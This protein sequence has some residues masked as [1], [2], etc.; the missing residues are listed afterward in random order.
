LRLCASARDAF[1]FQ[2][3]LDTFGAAGEKKANILC[4]NCTDLGGKNL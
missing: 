3:S 2:P 1:A 4:K